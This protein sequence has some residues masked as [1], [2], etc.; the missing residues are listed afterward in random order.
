[1]KRKLLTTFLFLAFLLPA[2]SQNAAEIENI[3]D[4]K[5]IT[6]EQ[7]VYFTLAAALDIPRNQAFAHAVQNGWL[8]K[9]ARSTNPITLSSLSLLVMK[10]FDIKGGMM[11]RITGSRRYAF[12]EMKYRDF[13][14][15]RVYPNQKVSGEQFLQILSTAIM[16][17]EQ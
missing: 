10:A 12:R 5:E 17:N 11:Y 9:A 1:M 4:T 16:E 7:A 3:L 8:P 13:I 15:G 6:F 2:F 14:T